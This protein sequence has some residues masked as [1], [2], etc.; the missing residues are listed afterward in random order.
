MH[1]EKT[2]PRIVILGGGTGSYVLAS[3]LSKTGAHVSMIMTMADDG[4][5]N[6]VIRDGFGLLPTSGIRQAIV[7]LSES[8]NVLRKLFTYRYHKGG[9][10]IEGMTFGNLF[11]AAMADIMGSQKLGIQETCKL[12]QV[13]GDIIPISYDDVRLVAKYADGSVVVGEH[14]I[15]EPTHAQG[16]RIVDLQTEPVAHIEKEAKEAI[17]QADLIVIGPGDFYTNTVANLVIKGVSEA[18][19]KSKGKVLFVA[20]LMTSPSETPDYK[21]SDFFKDLAKYLPLQN[22]DYVL[23]NSNDNYPESSLKAYAKEH[24]KPV[25]DDLTKEH[26]HSG[27]KIIR[28]DILSDEVPE[29]VKGD[30]LARSMIRHDSQKLAGEVYKIA[31]L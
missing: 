22:I 4:G 24:A 20:N 29:K 5:S 19:E 2:N 10:N 6:K 17:E 15:D 16:L 26:L 23:V 18:I 9:E 12:L 14:G 27:V 21:L 28:A 25:E 13:K 8:Q 30:K 31:G 1:K 3:G 7:A 11:M